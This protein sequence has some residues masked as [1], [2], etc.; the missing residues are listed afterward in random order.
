MDYDDGLQCYNIGHGHVRIF[1]CAP[2]LSAQCYLIPS[3]SRFNSF[4]VLNHANHYPQD[5]TTCLHPI[6]LLALLKSDGKS[7]RNSQRRTRDI[8]TLD[9]PQVSPPIWSALSETVPTLRARLHRKLYRIIFALLSALSAGLL[10]NF[11]TCIT[12]LP[13]HLGLSLLLVQHVNAVRS[14]GG[15]AKFPHPDRQSL[16]AGR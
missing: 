10:T 9:N 15:L 2:S 1:R 13:C 4:R 11:I 3:L 12:S 16:G 8:A 14:R 7:D 6:C 5:I